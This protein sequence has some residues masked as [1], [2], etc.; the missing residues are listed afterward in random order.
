MPNINTGRSLT[1][2]QLET[3]FGGKKPPVLYNFSASKFSHLKAAI[4]TVTT[5]TGRAVILCE[6]DSTTLGAGSVPGILGPG[7]KTNSYPSKLAA[8][9]S[10]AGVNTCLESIWGDGGIGAAIATYDSRIVL[11][12][13]STGVTNGYSLGGAPF[14]TNSATVAPL[15]WTPLT[16]TD[17]CEIY[18]NTNTTFGTFNA[19][20]NGGSNTLVSCV[21]GGIGVGKVTLSASLGMNT[22]N[23]I[24]ASGAVNVVGFRAYNSAVKAVD[25]CN[26]GY[27]GAYTGIIKGNG[28]D[29][30]LL[31]LL[32][33]SL[34]IVSAGINDWLGAVPPA[35]TATWF[36]GMLANTPSS[37]SDTMI[38]APFTSGL[39]STPFATQ[40]PYQNVTR[41]AAGSSIP[42]I[43]INR[44]WGSWNEAN[45]KGY[46]SPDWIH[47]SALGYSSAAGLMYGAMSPFIF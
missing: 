42:F 16:P 38:M 3:L 45:A 35:N 10:A 22:Y 12:N 31:T 21:S 15:A 20:A 43:D 17:T 6:G 19:N 29:A 30:P 47:P 7:T 23:A 44:F 11:G 33:P 37:V 28:W 27:G 9:L 32:A 1:P 36:A 26:A 13:W 46:Y 4:A 25:V 18:Y 2:G 39:L 5:G 8:M 41:A 34:V 14:F 24:W 40:V